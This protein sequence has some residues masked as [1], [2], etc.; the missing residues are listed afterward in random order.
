MKLPLEPEQEKLDGEIRRASFKFYFDLD[1]NFCS[2]K[3]L[4]I[5]MAQFRWTSICENCYNPNNIPYPEAR[6]SCTD[7]HHHGDDLDFMIYYL[8]LEP[9]QEEID[10]EIP[11]ASF[12]FCFDLD[13]NFCMRQLEYKNIIYINM[14]QFRWTSICENCYNPNNIP[15]PEAIISCTNWHHH[16]DDI[17]FMNCYDNSP[18]QQQP[19]IHNNHQ[20]QIRK[21]ENKY[22]LNISI[23]T[24]YKPFVSSYHIWN[25]GNH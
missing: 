18:V 20:N 6:V 23:R 10:G 24:N 16:G 7:W 25:L 13:I 8:P 15:Y 21:Q 9:E 19:T 22:Q 1:I 17:D 11:R 12:K 14:A 3:T 5:N 2:P 4:Y